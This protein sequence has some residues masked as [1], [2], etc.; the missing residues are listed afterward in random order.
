L[1]TFELLEISSCTEGQFLWMKSKEVP[2]TGGTG[3]G[4]GIRMGTFFRFNSGLVLRGHWDS[5][6]VVG[7]EYGTPGRESTSHKEWIA[8]RE[9]RFTNKVAIVSGG[10]TGIGK[11][12]AVGFANE[13]ATVVIA[14][15]REERLEEVVSLLQE[16][17]AVA[18][19][20]VTD[21][22]KP[23]D[24][25]RLVEST[26]RDFGSLD[27][28]LANASVPYDNLI[29]NVTD[30]DI[31]RVTDINVKGTYYQL[32]EATRAMKKQKSGSIVVISSGSSVV[33]HPFNSL[34]CGTKAAASNMVRALALELAEEGIR[35]N[36]VAPGIIDTPMPRSRAAL[37]PDPEAFFAALA[38]REPMKRL[39]TPE[40]VANVVMFLASDEATFVTGALYTVD[41]GFL[42]GK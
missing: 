15:R 33:G 34:Y 37:T 39:G 41:G 18:R 19:Y 12:C 20:Q 5:R 7:R 30:E 24:V 32:R 11:A 9:D 8:M 2:S 29:E 40:E 27:I 31:D 16:M 4:S 26:V 14:G 25:R 10:G 35:V 28:Y 1:E 23:M 38:D 3:V 6:L 22:S 21:I 13:G 42:A 17:G 36:D